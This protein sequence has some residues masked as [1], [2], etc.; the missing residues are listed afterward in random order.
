MSGKGARKLSVRAPQLTAREMRLAELM[1]DGPDE[2]VTLEDGTTID[3]GWPMTLAAAARVSGVPLRRARQLAG[4]TALIAAF[5]QEFQALRRAEGPRNVAT[6]I[7]VRDRIGDDTAADRAVR[8]KAIATIEGDEKPGLTVNVNAT[9]HVANI[10]PGYVIRLP[11]KQTTPASINGADL[12]IE[13]S[14]RKDRLKFGR[15]GVFSRM[16]TWPAL[17]SRSAFVIPIPRPARGSHPG[18]LLR[19]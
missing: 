9:T 3:A 6:A 1:T 2:D 10:V 7:S 18:S 14:G 11:A 15:H 5:N 16:A 13:G 12:N 17:T 19:D 8:L 4:S